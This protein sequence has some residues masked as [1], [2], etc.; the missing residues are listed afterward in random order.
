[1]NIVFFGSDNFAVPALRA[2]IAGAHKISCVV[3]Q[4][5]RKKGRGLHLEGT[6][7]KA[8]AS[9][10]HL[11]IH[12][13]QMANS[14]ETIKFLKCLKPDVFVVIAYGQ[15]L[16]QGLLDIP[17]I[18]PLNV[19]ASL[20]PKYRGAAPINWALING[21]R[22]TG[23]TVIKMSEKMDAGPV[24]LQEEIEV[25]DEDTAIILENKLSKKA[26]ELLINSLKI[27]ENKTYH[28]IPQDE[29]KVSFAPKL[30]KSDAL[31]NWEESAQDTYNLIRGCLGWPGAFTYYN[32]R[33]LK[34]YKARVEREA[35]NQGVRTP[36]EIIGVS[37]EGIIVATGKDYLRIEE[38]QIEGKKR[39]K[40]KEFIAGHKIIPGD[41][42]G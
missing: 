8:L 16:S 31:I 42:L 3:T 14:P 10:S 13:P 35:E 39:I 29:M 34:V 30:R 1:M 28:L 15:L 19:H 11:T 33:L 2:L 9:E 27:I 6:A 22:T 25:S 32:G 21:E 26:A 38:L 4:P 18:L 23:V 36:G 5:D 17:R 24:I 12:Q 7:V 41:R 37:Y 20:L 40:A